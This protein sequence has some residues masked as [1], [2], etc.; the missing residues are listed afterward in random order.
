MQK[1]NTAKKLKDAADEMEEDDKEKSVGFQRTLE[2]NSGEVAMAVLLFCVR[3][4][5]ARRA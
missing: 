2:K 4:L 5:R 1:Q 3:I